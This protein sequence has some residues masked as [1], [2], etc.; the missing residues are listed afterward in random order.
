[1]PLPP[2]PFTPT[3]LNAATPGIGSEWPTPNTGANDVDSLALAPEKRSGADFLI[4]L[5]VLLAKATKLVKVFKVLS[6][7]LS[8]LSALCFAG[9]LS[10]SMGVGVGVGITCLLMIHEIGYAV[11]IHRMGFG[12]RFPIF[13]PFLGAAIFAPPGLTRREEASMAYAGPLW[14][15]GACLL[16]VLPYF[17]W[18]S[19]LWFSIA[20]TGVFINLF[21]MFPLAPLD[22][23]RILRGSHEGLRYV[24]LAGL[25]VF[26]FL[27]RDPGMLL[28]WVIVLSEVSFLSNR[29]R[30]YF[31]LGCF[32]VLLG[33][34]PLFH[35]HYQRFRLIVDCFL[36]L[37]LSISYVTR[38][39][40]AAEP[41]PY[42]PLSE[43]VAWGVFWLALIA[44]Q[45][46]VFLALAHI[47]KRL[48][49]MAQ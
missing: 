16:A 17:A 19:P 38:E 8:L 18:P 23:G 37:M 14:G 12:F 6:V 11:G 39:G 1:M 40:K 2:S 30:L 41:R 27:L 45:V 20:M 13:I 43:R 10:F 9:V 48:P 32:L 28:I 15:T 22:G 33:S 34:I 4:R 29:V 42:G 35:G 36:V 47:E 24:G 26:T 49:G 46:S 21:N 3:K 5:S 7:A 25:V 31:S 44:V